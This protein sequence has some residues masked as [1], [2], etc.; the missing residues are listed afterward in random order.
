MS[1]VPVD[2]GTA[3]KGLEFIKKAM[4]LDPQSDYLWRLGEAQFHLERYE[5]AAATLLRA[6]KRLYIAFNTR[7]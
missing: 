3:A 6:T 4:R 1:R 7:H 5:E 2:L